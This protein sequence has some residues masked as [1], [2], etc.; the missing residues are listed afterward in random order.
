MDNPELTARLCEGNQPL[1]LILDRSLRL[2]T[3]LNV[4]DDSTKTLVFTT[5][6]R[7]DTDV[8]EYIKINFDFLHQEIVKELFERNIQSILIEGGRE[9]LQSFIDIDLWDEARV[10]I[11]C[12][13]ICK[14]ITAP[15]LN[16]SKKSVDS[17]ST[18]Q[19]IV[20]YNV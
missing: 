19:L 15:L 13:K 16:S 11:G 7:K 1:R 3:E 18:D 14:G 5:K 10:F 12:E 8:T 6:Y 4:F 17:F 9:T 2:S 20:H